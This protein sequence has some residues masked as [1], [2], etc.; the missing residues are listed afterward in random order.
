M[1]TS[2]SNPNDGTTAKK[3]KMIVFETQITWTSLKSIELSKRGWHSA[4]CL[5]PFCTKLQKMATVQQDR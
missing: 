5:I 4:Q 1:L 3:Y 2:V